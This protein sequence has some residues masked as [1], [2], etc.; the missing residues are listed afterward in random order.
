MFSD[1]YPKPDNTFYFPGSAPG[2]FA[3]FLH[4]AKAQS[5]N[6]V[7]VDGIQRFDEAKDD[8]VTS[9]RDIL[10]LFRAMRDVPMMDSMHVY[11]ISHKRLKQ[12]PTPEVLAASKIC[13]LSHGTWDFDN[14][15]LDTRVE[16]CVR[17]V[18][19]Q[20]LVWSS[21]C[22]PFSNFNH[23]PILYK[24]GD[25]FTLDEPFLT[26][27][28][29]R[30]MEMLLRIPIVTVETLINGVMK[31][32]ASLVMPAVLD[33]PCP[34]IVFHAL[35][36]DDNR[37]P[38][39]LSP[40]LQ[41]FV[42]N[43]QNLCRIQLVPKAPGPTLAFKASFSLAEDGAF[44]FQGH[45][46]HPQP[47][48]GSTL[49]GLVQAANEYT[50]WAIEQVLASEAE[51]KLKDKAIKALGNALHI[52][53]AYFTTIGNGSAPYPLGRLGDDVGVNA[54]V[55]AAG[56]LMRC[57]TDADFAS[58]CKELLHLRVHI[59]ECAAHW[60]Q[61]FYY[62]DNTYGG[63]FGIQLGPYQ[64]DILVHG[65]PCVFYNAMA[66]GFDLAGTK[67]MLSDPRPV[68]RE[69]LLAAFQ[70]VLAL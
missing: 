56:I 51:T 36:A 39:D 17:W 1:L 52:F 24:L 66:H 54:L 11:L 26:P 9:T 43:V 28:L 7:F 2:A 41:M 65:K 49:A 63:A 30:H 14:M 4:Q 18:G 16:S 57:A 47:L 29:H 34:S 59:Q 46:L 42:K 70:R 12:L 20:E 67:M 61:T 40:S 44:T 38:R 15:P 10:E 8:I 62:V 23:T 21:M 25:F 69:L 58:F 6:L 48:K 13:L 3:A 27:F 68:I 22:F 64:E 53:P 35:G 19:D 45:G 32:F 5:K 60:R 37:L 55:Q 50:Y 33:G 31:M